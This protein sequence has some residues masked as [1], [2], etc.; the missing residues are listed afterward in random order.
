M[1]TPARDWLRGFWAF[2]R[3]YVESAIHT[4]TL[5][6]LAIF[7]LLVF[8]DPAFAAL[9]IASYVVPPLVLYVLANDET[10]EPPRQRRT[11][12]RH[13]SPRRAEGA[14]QSTSTFGRREPLAQ[15]GRDERSD[16]KTDSDGANGDTDSDGANTDF[17]ADGIGGDT[18]SD[19]SD[20]DTDSD[21]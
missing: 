13:S 16:G 2:Y 4:A 6:A 9:A 10:V 21:R 5:A 17:D 20:G 1:R 14:E 7:G 15:N 12:R 3:E 18:D 11:D 8:V 19:R